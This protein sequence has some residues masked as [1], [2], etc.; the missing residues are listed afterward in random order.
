MPLPDHSN[1]KPFSSLKAFFEDQSKANAVQDTKVK[2]PVAKVKANFFPVGERRAS[3]GNN[4][5]SSE[6]GKA[7]D[8]DGTKPVSVEEIA[9]DIEPGDGASGAPILVEPAPE[10]VQAT[11][12]AKQPKVLGK[13]EGP[14]PRRSSV[15]SVMPAKAS[16]LSSRHSTP[17]KTIPTLP[18][19]ATKSPTS[20][21]SPGIK[22]A[23]SNCQTAAATAKTYTVPPAVTDTPSPKPS[24]TF[25]KRSTPSSITK[26]PPTTT[27][28]RTPS[29]NPISTNTPGT[30][31]ITSPFTNRTTSRASTR[32][33]DVGGLD[34]LLR[35]TTASANRAREGRGRADSLSSVT[36]TRS[37]PGTATTTPS[38][39]LGATSKGRKEGTGRPGM[40]K[41]AQVS[42]SVSEEV[43]E[44]MVD[45]SP[46]SSHG[47]DGSGRE[48]SLGT[49]VDEAAA[50]TV[51]VEKL[52][53]PEK[54]AANP[55]KA[56]A[57][58]KDGQAEKLVSVIEDETSIHVYETRDSGIVMAPDVDSHNPD[59]S[60]KAV[61][62]V[63]TTS[64]SNGGDRVEV[65][66]E[67]ALKDTD[68]AKVLD[69]NL[70]LY[71]M[72]K[73]D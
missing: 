43:G 18:A 63:Q 23:P 48:S 41:A 72:Q 68:M 3:N 28:P 5:A 60:T 12:D 44:E 34:R 67:D 69:A 46:V 40:R 36:S 47:N 24:H 32:T 38:K 52:A 17:K 10:K 8:T 64:N 57:T 6:K 26:T 58:E 62:Q 21:K 66:L 51:P 4:G 16:S 14:Q 65:A 29:S 1:A 20:I 7:R 27:S 55:S 11:S 42:G 50:S 25:L 53:E 35:P 31:P 19:A 37:R 22:K 9:K 71:D 70:R 30:T 15:S 2:P 61:E 59:L 33:S 54:E 45:M 73:E 13:A 49:A 56:E 39:I